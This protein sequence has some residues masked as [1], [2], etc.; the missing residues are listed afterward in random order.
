[1]FKLLVLIIAAVLATNSN[2]SESD[3]R[4]EVYIGVASDKNGNFLYR[5]THR[6]SFDRDGAVVKAKTTYHD[7]KE[8][9]IGFLESNF[10]RSVTA[11]EYTFR[12][13]RSKDGHGIRYREDGGL[14]MFSIDEQDN[15]QTKDLDVNSFGDSLV[16]GGQGFHYYLKKNLEEVQK[17]KRIPVVLLI[18]GR[19]DH[20]NFRLDFVSKENGKINLK[21][22]IRNFLLRFFAPS[23][24]LVYEKNSGHLLRYEGASNLKDD[25]G[26]LLYVIIDY[27]YPS[28]EQ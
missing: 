21:V 12:D 3:K 24:E 6:V 18:P 23:L 8:Q 13:F 10:E 28:A 7:K 17:R 14:V 25:S 9:K 20:Y 11:P 22:E 26:E 15:E 16:L 27:Q 5:E 2:S 19:L 1:M 4:E